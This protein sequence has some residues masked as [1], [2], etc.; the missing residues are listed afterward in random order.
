M[1]ITDDDRAI[2]AHIVIDPDA[3]VEHASTVVGEW[4]VTAKINKYRNAYLSQKDKSD[5]KTRAIREIE[6]DINI[7]RGKI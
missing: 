1:K 5:Y 2:L 3:W 7:K 4:A 6:A